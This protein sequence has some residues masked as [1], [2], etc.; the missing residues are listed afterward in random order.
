MAH[1][2][3]LTPGGWDL[4]LDGRGGIRTVE[5]SAATLQNVACAVRLF[6][7]DACLDR[8]RGIAHFE[9]DISGRLNLPLLT[10]RVNRAAREVPGVVRADT[11]V[12]GFEGRA[13]QAT[14]RVTTGDGSTSVLPFRAPG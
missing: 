10:T 1:T 5:G 3:C 14:I 7:R 2:L 9:T 8:T 4:Q 12:S 13:L 6:T 11:R